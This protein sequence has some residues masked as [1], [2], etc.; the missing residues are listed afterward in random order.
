MKKL[1][2][3]VFAVV[4]CLGATALLANSGQTIQPSEGS[5]A[6]F[7]ADGAFRDGLYVGR[8]AAEHGQ[9][10]RPAV[11]RW[12]TNQDRSMFAAGYR[13]GYN[14]TLAQLNGE[15]AQPAD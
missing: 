15:I 6:R 1:S 11:G 8:L 13:R 7:A 10:L 4:L 5:E 3:C 2:I 9:R 14:E 12:S